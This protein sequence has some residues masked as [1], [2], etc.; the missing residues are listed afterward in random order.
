MKFVSLKFSEL[1]R[2]LVKVLG[3]SV[4]TLYTY[5]VI[6]VEKYPGALNVILS[7][8]IIRFIQGKRACP[9]S[10]L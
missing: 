3:V 2:V 6:I 7:V 4:N 1:F 10:L 8:V 9:C 5:L